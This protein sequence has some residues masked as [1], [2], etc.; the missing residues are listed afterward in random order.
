MNSEIKLDTKL[1]G[2]IKGNFYVPIISAWI[3]LGRDRG[4]SL[5]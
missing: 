5:T 3:P 1:V 4:D 2:D